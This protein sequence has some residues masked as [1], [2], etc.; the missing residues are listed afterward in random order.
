MW[1]DQNNKH[2][3]PFISVYS[4]RDLH[5]IISA[6]LIR[7]GYKHPQ[8]KAE[9][10]VALKSQHPAAQTPNKSPLILVDCIEGGCAATQRQTHRQTGV[11]PGV[12]FRRSQHP[13]AAWVHDQRQLYTDRGPLKYLA[14]NY[15]SSLG[16]STQPNTH[17][18]IIERSFLLN[19]V[20]LLPTSPPPPLLSHSFLSLSSIPPF[21]GAIVWVCG[22]LLF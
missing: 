14:N 7:C 1:H 5:K 4:L 16:A 2:I 9:K 13:H 18:S 6:H 17:T 12:Y 11:W 21:H 8:I 20:F 3:L 15:C 22:Q 10:T 19:L